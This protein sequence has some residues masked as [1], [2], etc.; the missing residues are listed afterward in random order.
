MGILQTDAL[1]TGSHV[2][3]ELEREIFYLLQQT[4]EFPHLCKPFV[5]L[6]GM[7]TEC[8]LVHFLL[9]QRTQATLAEH[10]AY[11][12]ESYLTF[13]VCWINHGCKVTAFS[14]E[15]RHFTVNISFDGHV[16]PHKP[17]HVGK[18]KR[19]LAAMGLGG[20]FYDHRSYLRWR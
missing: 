8:H 11:L 4:A 12:R 17:V 3:E 10:G 19:Q 20:S 5:H 18:M 7:V 2:I 14:S 6:V 9:A 13:K 1:N 15:S 16:E